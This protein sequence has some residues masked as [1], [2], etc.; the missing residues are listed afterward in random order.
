MS[1]PSPWADPDSPTEPGAPY[2]GPPATGQPAYA[3]PAYAQP[4]YGPPGHGTAPAYGYGAPAYAYPPGYPPPW[5]VAPPRA[6]K[7]GQVIAAGVLAFAQGG[8]VLLSSVYVVFLASFAGVVDADPSAAPDEMGAL[9]TEGVVLGIVQVASAVLLVVGGVMALNTRKRR[10]LVVL[11][12]GFAVQVLLCLYWAVRLSAL[13]DEIPG[14][15]PSS[16]FLAFTLLF[17]ASPV[18]GLGLVLLGS[19]RRWFDA[20]AA[21]A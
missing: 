4:A 8:L 17:A 9:A 16:A 3:Q 20:A 21:P 10:A 2:A 7:P 1:G 12:A 13:A 15:D 19:G 5:P 18:V 14:A 6:R 11:V